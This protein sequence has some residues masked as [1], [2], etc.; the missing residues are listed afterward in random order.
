M[1]TIDNIIDLV[2]EKTFVKEKYQDRSPNTIYST[3]IKKEFVDEKR[4]LKGIMTDLVTKEF[5]KS[6]DA[7]INFFKTVYENFDKAIKLYNVKKSGVTGQVI[8]D[9]DIFFVYK[10]GNVLRIVAE[11][12]LFEIPGQTSKVMKHY[13]KNFFKKS[14]ADF[15][16]YV[17]P[18]FDK[19]IHAGRNLFDELHEDVTLI[20]YLVQ[21]HVR[22]IFLQDMSK[23]FDYY[24][25]NNQYK[26]KIISNY[27]DELNKSNAVQDESSPFYKSKFVSLGIDDMII[28]KGVGGVLSGK[29]ITVKQPDMRIRAVDQKNLIIQLTP[30]QNRSR[31]PSHKLNLLKQQQKQIYKTHNNSDDTSTMYISDNKL[32]IKYTHI[33]AVFGLV[34]TKHLFMTELVN[35]GGKKSQMKL[36]GELIDVS[37][38]D[39]TD[40]GLQ[41][42][43]N[44]IQQNTAHYKMLDDDDKEVISFRSYSMHELIHDLEKILFIQIDFPWDDKK[45][46]KRINRLIYLYFINMMEV[47]QPLTSK[48]TYLTKFQNMVL[49]PLANHSQQ[50][51]GSLNSFINSPSPYLFGR[52]AKYLA[53]L[54]NVFDPV[55]DA[56]K[57]TDFS[58]VVSKNI[59]KLKQSIQKLN[60]FSQSS[61]VPE[62]DIYNFTQMGGSTKY[63]LSK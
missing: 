8:T 51:L 33:T 42:F 28:T 4:E 59:M 41:L 52:F 43:F 48:Y 44:N 36:G 31:T 60:K 56:V 18:K 39:K 55:N 2:I 22:N 49:Q 38:P 20:A 26:I 27:I 46:A 1:S 12:F 11:E 10:G 34:R 17:N 5:I 30:I 15:S 23:Y 37:I 7:I 50:T 24:K 58:N 62:Q 19:V 61:T 35:V 63:C 57:L 16:I 3:D 40:G 25:Y 45:Y 54:L 21:N 47:N 14:D 9:D 6:H 32:N 29:K 13:Y 53:K